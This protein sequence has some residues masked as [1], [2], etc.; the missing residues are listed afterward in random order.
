V[1]VNFE[2][3]DGCW[4][5]GL[6]WRGET[7][8]EERRTRKSEMHTEYHPSVVGRRRDGR[9]V[10]GAVIHIL[11][12]RDIYKVMRSVWV[13]VGWVRGNELWMRC[14]AM[15]CSARDVRGGRDGWQGGGVDGR[16]G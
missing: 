11:C 1:E 8:L 4:G 7:R 6:V 3:E 14:N 15:R 12:G 10:V 2:L 16:R 9:H 13:R 5:G